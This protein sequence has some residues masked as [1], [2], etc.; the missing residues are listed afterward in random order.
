MDN[1]PINY[2]LSGSS[3]V[4]SYSTVYS[5][6]Q[7]KNSASV[8]SK[9]KQSTINRKFGK[10]KRKRRFN[11]KMPD[12]QLMEIQSSKVLSSLIQ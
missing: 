6:K 12:A 8:K 5:K 7:K 9:Y 2:V 10:K 4:N 11:R 3:S 1:D